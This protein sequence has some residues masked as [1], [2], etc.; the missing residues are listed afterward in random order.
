MGAS[1]LS[2]GA[3]DEVYAERGSPDRPLSLPMT[4]TD[5]ADLVGL[6]VETVC[7]A[8][9]ELKDRHLL[10]EV[11]QPAGEAESDAL[12]PDYGG[13]AEAVPGYR[14]HQRR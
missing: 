3:G 7:R 2:L 8:L 6:R 11:T 13:R 1:G 12:R 9:K 4:R 5:I 10:E 14:D